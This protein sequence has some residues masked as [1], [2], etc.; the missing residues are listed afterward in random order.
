MALLLICTNFLQE[1]DELLDSIGGLGA[2]VSNQ[3]GS[4]GG[5]K[6]FLGGAELCPIVFKKCPK[7]FY[8]GSEHFFWGVRP[9]WLRA[10]LHGTLCYS[11]VIKQVVR[12]VYGYFSEGLFP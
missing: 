1:C 10:W 12:C 5:A 9:P 3:F 4:L 8:R 2:Q 6:S 11:S 7:K